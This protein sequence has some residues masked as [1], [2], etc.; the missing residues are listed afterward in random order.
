[1]AN[2]NNKFTLIGSVITGVLAIVVIIFNLVYSPLNSALSKE[3]DA[4]VAEDK[5]MSADIIRGDKANQ[6]AFLL[7]FKEISAENKKENR[8]MSDKISL[9]QI[10]IAIIKKEIQK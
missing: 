2:G 6:D 5:E 8:E 3:A 1:M 10:D 4:R 7:A 9:M